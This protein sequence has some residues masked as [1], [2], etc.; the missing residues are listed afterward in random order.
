[1][2]LPVAISAPGWTAIGAVGGAL[3]GASAGGMVDWLLG[4][5]RERADAKAGARLVAGQI[6]AAESQVEAAEES[7]EWWGFYGVPIDSWDQYRDAL[8]VK[9]PHDDFEAVAQAIFV[10]ESLRQRMPV[11]PRAIAEI[12]KQGFAKLKYPSKL[13]AIRREAAEAYN[14]LADIGGHAREG[15]LIQRAA[16]RTHSA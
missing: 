8:A 4:L 6:A 7:G 5:R 13:T 11:S 9:L 1:V 2:I 12:E 10:L 14:S 3:V 16:T 15:E